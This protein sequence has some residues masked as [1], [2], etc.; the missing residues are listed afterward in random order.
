M[1]LI[2]IKARLEIKF[3]TKIGVGIGKNIYHQ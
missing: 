3:S 2:P 1:S